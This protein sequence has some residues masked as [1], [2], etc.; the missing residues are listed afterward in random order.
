MSSMAS[1][2]LLKLGVLGFKSMQAHGFADFQALV[3][4][5]AFVE[6]GSAE[7]FLAA[8]LG[9]ACDGGDAVQEANDLLFAL[10]AVLMSVT[11]RR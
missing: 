6:G 7:A 11:L 4:G 2:N 10:L 9:H 1:T 8:Q 5:P 3:L